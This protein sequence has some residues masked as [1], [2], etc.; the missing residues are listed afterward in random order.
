M[1]EPREARAHHDRE[2]Y[3]E[4]KTDAVR[5][6]FILFFRLVT[7]CFLLGVCGAVVYNTLHLTS[8]HSSLD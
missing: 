3:E 6:I 2:E 7:L 1:R 8:E 4:Y 5:D